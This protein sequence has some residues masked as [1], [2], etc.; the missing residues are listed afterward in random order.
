MTK[1]NKIDRP[2]NSST[3]ST[4]ITTINL[5]ARKLDLFRPD[6]LLIQVTLLE[7]LQSMHSI[8]L[9]YNNQLHHQ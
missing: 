4:L 5:D 6:C 8:K 9:A 2:I 1:T 3:L 7:A